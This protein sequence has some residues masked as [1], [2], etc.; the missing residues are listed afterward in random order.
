MSWTCLV[1]TVF[2][3]FN[4]LHWRYRQ[5]IFLSGSEKILLASSGATERGGKKYD[6]DQHAYEQP[7]L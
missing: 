4:I 6:D 1:L 7:V 2:E 5:P 3:R